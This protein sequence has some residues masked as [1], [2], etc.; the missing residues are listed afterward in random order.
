MNRK[1]SKLITGI[2]IFIIPVFSCQV[3]KKSMYTNPNA[4]L[5]YT[6]EGSPYIL[7]SISVNAA[8]TLAVQTNINLSVMVN[9]D[10]AIV[11]ALP[12]VMGFNTS[13]KII[14]ISYNFSALDNVA[15]YTTVADI[16]TSYYFVG[17]GVNTGVLPNYKKPF[18]KSVPYIDRIYYT[19]QFFY[20]YNIRYNDILFADED[21]I[22]ASQ[23]VVITFSPDLPGATVGIRTN[24]N[25]APL[26]AATYNISISMLYYEMY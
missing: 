19:S 16:S 23:K 7:R 20:N 12:L 6:Q 18:A 2:I 13:N 25:T 26:P 17:D 15:P 21:F 10:S 22:D 14:P 5:F 3:N 11:A 4:K 24:A 8:V 9:F 1:F